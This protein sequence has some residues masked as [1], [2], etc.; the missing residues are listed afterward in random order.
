M[1]KNDFLKFLLTYLTN[2]YSENKCMRRHILIDN[3][4]KLLLTTV[5]SFKRLFSTF[6]NSFNRL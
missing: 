6:F 3:T 5:T 1:T 2:N 4:I